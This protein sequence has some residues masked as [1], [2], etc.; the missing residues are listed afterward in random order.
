MNFSQ[1]ND[2]ASAVVS[3]VVQVRNYNSHNLLNEKTKF[4]PV[5]I[6]YSSPESYTYPYEDEYNTFVMMEG[7]SESFTSFV[8][9]L[10]NPET[11]D[12]SRVLT[13]SLKPNEITTTN[14]KETKT[15]LSS[16]PPAS[17]LAGSDGFII[18][19]RG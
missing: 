9:K 4:Q 14:Y 1:Y 15:F 18:D 12:P 10:I 2:M 13:P 6:G 16:Q 11:R 7:S 5:A 8:Y 3:E 19:T 17:F